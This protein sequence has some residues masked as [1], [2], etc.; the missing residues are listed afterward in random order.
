MVL[1]EE[2]GPLRARMMGRGTAMRRGG[3]GESEIWGVEEERGEVR[4]M[5]EGEGS[6]DMRKGEVRKEGKKER[7]EGEFAPRGGG[8]GGAWKRGARGDS[9]DLVQYI[10]HFIIQKNPQPPSQPVCYML[11]PSPY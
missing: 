3:G 5:L 8:G 6:S 10:N 11:L 1:P 2:E 4:V 7:K 9:F